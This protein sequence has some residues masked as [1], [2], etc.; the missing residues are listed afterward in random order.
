M[1]G[2][3][4]VDLSAAKVESNWQ[5]KGYLDKL[6]TSSEQ[7]LIASASNP[8]VMV[9]L[10]WTM[11]EASYKANN[12]ITHIREYAPIKIECEIIQISDNI[13]YGTVQYRERQYNVKTSVFKEFIHTLALYKST[14]FSI[15]NE[16][17][18][19]NYPLDYVHYLNQ[20]NYLSDVE[21]IKKNEHGVPNIINSTN[22]IIKPISISHHGI[23][24][25]VVSIKE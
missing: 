1:I 8:E 4:I 10:L 19:Q 2:N 11:K 21:I 14:D 17:I 3:D 15:F 20:N 16:I 23:F 6:F 18:V 24:L 13:Y 5:R 25:S 9:W 7:Q 22:G 12:R